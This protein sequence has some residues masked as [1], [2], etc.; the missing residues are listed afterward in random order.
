MPTVVG[1]FAQ[2]P[3]EVLFSW[4]SVLAISLMHMGKRLVL[5]DADVHSAPFAGLAGGKTVSKGSF[6]Q[7]LH[8]PDLPPSLLDCTASIGNQQSVQAGGTVRL[9]SALG[10]GEQGQL[11][12]VNNPPL[13]GS[14]RYL[15]LRRTLLLAAG[16][17]DLI[18]LV[19]PLGRSA[20]AVQLLAQVCDAALF[21]ADTTM[22]Q[23][24]E[25]AS[26]AREADALRGYTLPS[27]CVEARDDGTPIPEGV[28]QSFFRTHPAFLPPH[29]KGEEG[30]ERL[31]VLTDGPEDPERLVQAVLDLA[32]LGACHVPETDGGAFAALYHE[33]KDRAIALFR[34]EIAP[35]LGTRSSAIAALKA[36][37]EGGGY[38][39]HDLQALAKFVVQKFRWEDP[40]PE[41]ESLFPVYEALLKA[42]ADGQLPGLDA[43][44]RI[45]LAGILCHMARWQ[46]WHGGETGALASRI[47]A[48]L[49]EAT[50]LERSALDCLR[51][52][53]GLALHAR[54]TGS[55]RHYDLAMEHM[56]RF[57]EVVSTV[58]L[59]RAV[60]DVVGDFAFASPKLW[61][62]VRRLCAT[63][64]PMDEYYSLW[65]GAVAETHLGQPN[66]A[67][68]LL[69]RLGRVDPDAFILAYHDPDLRPLW[70]GG[71][72]GWEHPPSPTP[73]R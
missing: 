29:R 6:Y 15:S 30:P 19:S 71:G 4:V 27:T 37:W 22:K 7:L 39:W 16:Q 5:I 34:A 35:R 28:W 3:R 56:H 57:G 52:G 32:L 44:V 41:S 9:L 18:L 64:M 61:E 24:L 53:E 72:L 70:E 10:Q 69:L 14:R 68:A 20:L 12:F 17:D 42:N 46:Q 49:L 67:L 60:L 48:L 47:E 50:T 21:L 54:L 51:V 1:I 25:L 13:V 31:L 55:S 8:N 2:V 66:K 38:T 65:W 62:T 26:M 45:D 36:L 40:D 58:E 63:L 33:D 59:H 43:R 23:V 11:E 73:Q